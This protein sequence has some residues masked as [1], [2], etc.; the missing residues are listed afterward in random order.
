MHFRVFYFLTN[1]AY[2]SVCVKYVTFYCGCWDNTRLRTC[3]INMKMYDIDVCN[4]EMH[5]MY[6]FIKLNKASGSVK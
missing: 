5:I 3:V 2:M 6:I 1:D 4:V